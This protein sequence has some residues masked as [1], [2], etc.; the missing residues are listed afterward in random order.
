MTTNGSDNRPDSKS[1]ETL[2]V[3]LNRYCL[4]LAKSNWDAE[5]LAQDTW[6]RAIGQLKGQGHK[7]PEAFLLRIAKNTWIDL[8]RRKAVFSQI[9]KRE[10]PK[11]MAMPEHGLYEIEMAFQALMKHLSPLQRTVFLLREVFGYSVA[12]ASEILNTTE[13]AVKAALHR[14]RQGLHAVKKDLET[15][16]LSAS[17]EEGFNVLL[18]ALAA[19][20]EAGDIARVVELLRLDEPNAAAIGTE[21]NKLLRNCLHTG[22]SFIQPESRMAA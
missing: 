6:V 14:A 2:Q 19:A 18:R 4:S 15:G 7:N 22:R 21:H 10:Q 8:S 13:G 16:V 17:R 5:D 3:V 11:E 9:L 20:Y 12:E 1:L